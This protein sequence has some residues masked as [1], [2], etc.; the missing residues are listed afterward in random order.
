[1]YNITTEHSVRRKT[2]KRRIT[3]MVIQLP[4]GLDLLTFNLTML[5]IKDLQEYKPLS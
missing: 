2:E 1:M 5:R 4:Y 3:I